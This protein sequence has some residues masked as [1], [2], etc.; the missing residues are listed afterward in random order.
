MQLDTV[1]QKARNLHKNGLNWRAV[2]AK[3]GITGGMA[4]RLANEPGYEPKSPHYRHVLGLPALIP[5]PACMKCGQVH[6]TK[7]CTNGTARRTTPRRVAVRCDDMR[8]AAGTILRNLE[9]E[10]VKELVNLLAVCDG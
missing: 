4:Y 2:G 1:C 8:S 3:M 10:Q 7:R 5:A 6:V 9:P